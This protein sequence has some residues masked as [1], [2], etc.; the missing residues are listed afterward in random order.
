MK[1]E[2][3]KKDIFQIQANARS[4]YLEKLRVTVLLD[5]LF[6]KYG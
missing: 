3:I 5:F 4:L 2:R 6:F 1:E